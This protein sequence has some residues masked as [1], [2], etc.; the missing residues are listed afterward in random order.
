MSVALLLQFFAFLHRFPAVTLTFSYINCTSWVAPIRDIYFS[1]LFRCIWFNNCC[2]YWSMRWR[3]LS[4]S[5]ATMRSMTSSVGWTLEIGFVIL[6]DIKTIV[7]RWKSLHLLLFP[8]LYLWEDPSET[9]YNYITYLTKM[10][11]KVQQSTLA[12]TL[13]KDNLATQI[14]CTVM[15]YL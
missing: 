13:K 1:L 7:W 6:S 12:S 10:L 3:W 4:L 11:P 15:C 9:N 5:A 8:I 14:I 2:L